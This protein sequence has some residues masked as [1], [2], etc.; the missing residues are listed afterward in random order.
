MSQNSS[1][2][3]AGPGGP[4]LLM[5]NVESDCFTDGRLPFWLD[6]FAVCGD[7]GGIEEVLVQN[8][9]SHCFV[10]CCMGASKPFEK[11]EIEDPVGTGDFNSVGCG[12]L[13]STLMAGKPTGNDLSDRTYG[14]GKPTTKE[15]LVCLLRTAH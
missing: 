4:S 10:A 2:D 13:W 15:C 14:P 8:T 12:S 7:Q 6:C 1:S 5:A 3:R 11:L 9:A